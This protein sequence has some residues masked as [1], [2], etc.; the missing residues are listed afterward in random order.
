MTYGDFKSRPPYLLTPWWK[1]V[2]GTLTFAAQADAADQFRW[3]LLDKWV[4]GLMAST[5]SDS[6][7]THVSY[8]WANSIVCPSISKALWD[9]LKGLF[10][11]V[12]IPGQFNL[13]YQTLHLRIDPENANSSMYKQVS[14]PI[15][16]TCRSWI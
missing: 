3:K 15:P 16:E 13:F 2:D 6:L 14:H 11:T 10:G 7:L 5:I 9:I 4:L 8:E 12:E 1:F